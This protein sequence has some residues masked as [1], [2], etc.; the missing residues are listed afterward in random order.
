MQSE[1]RSIE[2]LLLILTLIAIVFALLSMCGCKSGGGLFGVFRSGPPAPPRPTTAGAGTTFAMLKSISWAFVVPGALL[3]GISFWGP[4]SFLRNLGGTFLIIG[5]AAAITPWL[6]ERF[7][8]PAFYTILG[9]AVLYGL[10]WLYDYLW[11]YKR[12]RAMI[13]NSYCAATTE[14]ERQKHLG[15]IAVLDR[16]YRPNIDLLFRKNKTDALLN[17]ER[18]GQKIELLGTPEP[19]P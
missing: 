5:G 18:P 3:F 10:W 17:V 6:L 15:A 19:P 13:F 9:L 1:R 2:N 16:M 8:E 12:R 7:A 4:L 11:N 14:E